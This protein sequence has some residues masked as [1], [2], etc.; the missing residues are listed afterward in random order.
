[1]SATIAMNRVSVPG[2]GTAIS[3]T[4]CQQA[5]FD[6]DA[7]GQAIYRIPI[8]VPPGIAALQPQLAL[9]Y[10]HRLPNGILGVGWSLSGLSAITRIKATYAVDGFNGGINYD[11]NDRYALDGQ[12]L[13]NIQGDYGQPAT[14]YYT[15]M[16][17]WRYIQ[18]GNSDEDGFT[19]TMKNG[20]IARYG[21][22]A[23]SRIL[24]CGGQA[25]RVW[26][27]SALEDLNG[28]RIV[29]GY[30]QT[31]VNGSQNSGAYY[32]D[33][34]SYTVRDDQTASR[35]VQCTYENRP[36]PI[37]TYIGGYP[38]LTSYRLNQ[39]ITSLSGNNV[40]RTY[41][42]NYRVSKATQLS[43]I[44]SVTESGASS[45]GSPS[46][47]STQI[48]WQDIDN[49]G[50][51]I[52]T[53]SQL[54][55]HLKPLGVQPMDVNGDGRTDLVQLWEDS[56]NT[57]HATTYLATTINEDT[58]YIRASDSNLGAFPDTR[59]IL[60]MDVTGDGRN[61]L[62]IAYK[63]G[64][65][66]ILKLAVFLSDGQGFSDGG[67]FDTGDSWD[68]ANH[69]G[70]YATDVNGDGRTDLVEAYKHYDATY[71]SLLY[72]RSYLSL[73]GDGG[74]QLFTPA[75][76]SPTDDTADPVNLLAMWPL[77][78]NGDGMAD[79]VRVWERSTD[80]HIIVSAYLSVSTAIDNVSFSQK[81]DSDLGTFSLPD[82][83][84][85]LPADV[86]GDGMTDLLQIWQEPSGGSTTLHLT[87]FIGN[88]AGGF[89]AGPDSTF[90]NQTLNQNNFYPMGFNGGGQTDIL[91]KW[92]SGDNELMFTVYSSSPSGAFRL[93]T[94]FDAGVAGTTIANASFFPGDANG[95]G[96]ADL[97]RV[98]ASQ[99]SQPVIVPYTSSGA[100]PDF[101]DSI[102]NPIGGVTSIQYAP[103]SDS[104]VYSA[105][106]SLD[107]PKG[108]GLRYPNPLTPAQFPVQSVMGQALYVVSAYSQSNDSSLN[109]FAYIAS[110]E[111]SYSNAQIDL[112][113]RGWEGFET[114]SKLNLDNGFRI[115]QVYNQDYP[116]TGTSASTRIE[117]DGAYATDPRVPKDE[118]AVL[119]SMTNYVYQTY[120][121]ARGAT[122]PDQ[123]V[124]EVLKTGS[125]T[126][127]YDYGEDHFD[128]AI[129]MSFDYDDYGNQNKYVYLGYVDP[130]TG[131]P[132][133]PSEVVYRYNL[134]QNDIGQHGWALGYLLYAKTTANA[135]DIDITKFLPGDFQLEQKIYSAS[136]YN[137]ESQ[138][139]WDNSNNCNL[140]I[141][142]TY[143]TY[144]N[145][146]T[147]TR[148]GGF[149]TTYAYEPDYNTFLMQTTL[150]ANQQGI[151]LSMEYGYDPRYGTEVAMRDANNFIFITGLDAFGRKAA[152][153]GPVPD[154]A[155]AQGDPN[156]LTSLVTGSG[157]L[158]TA[159][160]SAIVVTTAA[161]QYLND[162]SG[163]NYIQ[164]N[165]LQSFPLDDNRDFLWK[166][167]YTDGLNR[168]CQSIQ[169]S[170][171]S[172]G[173]IMVLTDYSSTGKVVSQSLPFFSTIPVNPQTSFFINYAYDVVDRKISQQQ[174][175]GSDGSGQTLTTWYYDSGGVVNQT[176]ASGTD[177]AYEQIIKHHFYDSK[178]KVVQSIVTADNNATTTFIYDAIARVLSVTD[179]FTVS[180]PDGVCNAITYDSLDRKLT[181]NNPDQNTTGDSTIM[182]MTYRYDAL[183]GYLQDQI[184]AAGQ[185][186]IY[187]YDDLGRVLQASFADGRVIYYTYDSATVDGNGR[188]IQ[189]KVVAAD[190][191]VESQQDFAYD[192]YGN[193]NSVTLTIEGEVK[194]YVTASLFDPQ[195]RVVKQTLPNGSVTVS[196]YNSG[197]LVSQSMGDTRV[198]YPIEEYSALG[199]I[200]EM[201]YGKG[202]LPR[203]GIVTDYKY[204]PMGL[205]YGETVKNQA[206]TVIQ[207]G[208]SYDALN[209]VLGI[210]DDL[211]G[212]LSQTF[213]YFS[214]RLV[215]ANIPGFDAGSYSYDASGN[216]MNK[217][218]A[219]YTYNAHFPLTMVSGDQ[220]TYSA[221]QDA[222]G[223]TLTRTTGDQSLAFAYNSRGEL[224][225]IKSGDEIL[226]AALSDYTGRRIRETKEDGSA[227]LYIN[228]AYQVQRK[229]GKETVT[230]Y[231]LDGYGAAA[232]VK[233]DTSG[234]S[235]LYFRRDHKGSI[236]L[237]FGTDGMIASHITYDGYG[238][239]KMVSGP[240]NFAPKYEQRQWDSDTGLYY[241]GARYYD[242]LT[243]RFL[244]PDSLPGGSSYLEADVMNR[245]AF[246][247]NNPVNRIDPT[248]HN[249]AWIGG[250]L[251]GIT[252]LVAGIIIV[253]TAGAA[254]PVV[255]PLL[256]PALASGA[257]A[258]GATLS[259][260]AATTVASTLITIAGSAAIA[261][262]MS[263][264]AY[265]ATHSSNFSWKDY[266]I[267]TGISGAVGAVTGGILM[268]VSALASG[269]ENAVGSAA[270]NIFLSGAVTSAGDVTGQ[271]FTNLAEGARGHDLANGLLLSA[272]VGFL[273]GSVGAIAGYGFD[274]GAKYLAGKYTNWRF[275][276]QIAEDA[277]IQNTTEN[278]SLLYRPELPPTKLT[279]FA[280]HST[281]IASWMTEQKV[282]D[283]LS[284]PLVRMA[285]MTVLSGTAFP[286]FYTENKE[287]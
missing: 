130:S 123:Q 21:A 208:Y 107:F 15:E 69:I 201:V 173:N 83:L 7:S 154:I 91:N 252:I 198:D 172:A 152:K 236:T 131:D 18:A 197:L 199:K 182:A 74:G 142:Y 153:Q 207:L 46:L 92:I 250:L 287:G 44:E 274:R 282:G 273:F 178:D 51:D 241:F 263:A 32:L 232:S 275:G 40:I 134:Y 62:V 132:L 119:M 193:T 4:A 168:E 244:T 17:S 93:V 176:E 177:E 52:N 54:D 254:A 95:D 10:S 28:N 234:S 230:S 102:T 25:V 6:V 261:A 196:I 174:P 166:Q 110:Y 3:A 12:R 183:T 53:S 206:G 68:T 70:F 145:Q 148:P 188:L 170:G 211:D 171:Q 284:K 216:I 67:V 212:N 192:S 82:Q 224:V 266:W 189:G 2:S 143:D 108:A 30:T 264:T 5:N 272:G 165:A 100:Y 191:T 137:L 63:S 167:S 55:Q 48:V 229:D 235:T 257:A 138:S 116:L 41:T 60:P 90:E 245:F 277:Q 219:Q 190:G 139:R 283:I 147:E 126:D 80:S 204:N 262:G 271:F 279:S 64:A 281:E 39:V 239:P 253:A 255:A 228:A 200:G 227:T 9:S 164:I 179:P 81:V 86:N 103:I 36:D 20:Q 278:T 161:V 125:Q 260:T 162:G 141:A 220:T 16:Q 58:S 213:A 121:R 45:A 203:D 29:F 61:D 233:S 181:F 26:A 248:G 268:G 186:T 38:V 57:I 94:D 111:M 215:T 33:T 210:A 76:V 56:D 105:E 117:A 251:I 13:I 214:K 11:S 85:F 8:E 286:E 157:A 79:M 65:D 118:T 217:D 259:A 135:A 37:S 122:D 269:I 249:A 109:R 194:T 243:G 101:A 151:Q 159:F 136:T 1:M 237:T 14:V 112:L 35:F 97:I 218:G 71:G 24:A 209:Q 77:D 89:V 78:V 114:V 133:Y 226:M 223:N 113:G 49:P 231:L 240:D 256:A 66:N 156:Q 185:K 19:V 128:Y 285:Q 87:S 127:Q 242:P 175:A 246:E 23:D 160:L 187:T 104:T 73:F 31:P 129:G 195:K 120:V 247:L 42:L 43:C 267:Q 149:V 225:S 140:T 270:A 184:N 238:L 221:T 265:S 205:L 280:S 258:L 155:G 276:T 180:N 144:G 22:T 27:L 34:I 59:Q 222:C 84:G 88:G 146:K 115:V 75:I 150:P 106:S 98:S 47:P 50:F 96:K 169:Q 163:G 99:D 158:K 202:V 72:F 124:L